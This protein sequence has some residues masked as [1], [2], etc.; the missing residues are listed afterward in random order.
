MLKN[1]L[2]IAIRNILKYKT[3]TIINVF[4]LSV[5]ISVFVLIMLFVQN[6]KRYD[7]FNKNYHRVYRIVSGNPGD[8]NAFAG[9]PAPLGPALSEYI[10]GIDNMVRLSRT[11]AVLQFGQKAFNESRIFLV[12]PSIFRIFT[13][14]VIQGDQRI[15]LKDKIR[16]SLVNRWLRNISVTKI[17]WEKCFI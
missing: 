16:L 5:G 17:P 9:T 8:K 15:V 12:D 14:P 2:K 11:E 13:I 3:Y 1:Y 4:G 7:T 10:P 6:E